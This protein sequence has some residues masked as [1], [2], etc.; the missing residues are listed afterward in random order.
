MAKYHE[1]GRFIV[2]E[3]KDENEIDWESA[4]FHEEHAAELGELESMVTMAKLYLGMDRDV[5]VNCVV[6]VSMFVALVTMEICVRIFYDHTRCKTCLYEVAV[7]FHLS[8]NLRWWLLPTGTDEIITKNFLVPCHL[9]VN[10]FSEWNRK[11]IDLDLC[12]HQTSFSAQWRTHK[13]WGG[14]HGGGSGSRRSRSYVVH[15]S[16]IWNWTWTG[17]SQVGILGLYEIFLDSVILLQRC[18]D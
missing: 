16:G 17:H 6:E 9:H 1:V 10:I 14:L 5:L 11:P 3:N 12:I 8:I 18:A 7:P 2:G 4:I 13:Q 15:G